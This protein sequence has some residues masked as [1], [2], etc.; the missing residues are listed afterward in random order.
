MHDPSHDA[1]I[2]LDFFDD[3]VSFARNAESNGMS[4]FACSVL[5]DGFKRIATTCKD[6]KNV[7]A[8]LGIH[9]WWV[10]EANLHDFDDCFDQTRWIGEVGL[11]FSPRRPH[12][13]LQ[14]QV[15]EHVAHRCS[16]SGNKIMSIHSIRS[17]NSVMQILN[18]TACLHNNTCIF[19]WFSGSTDDLW[20]AIRAGCYFSINER[21]A[22]TKRAR[23]Q[24]KLIPV[25]RL[26]LET[27]LPPQNNPHV[28]IDD[29]V[30][31]LETAR[32][33]LEGIRNQTLDDQLA[34]NWL[35]LLRSTS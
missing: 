22:Q 5:P 31:S 8:G 34:K 25:E 24:L 23:E 35:E 28:T 7:H 30:S 29:V 10:A 32:T 14:I 13:D 6:H 4:L 33:S 27:D 12:H 20:R 2:H 18:Q 3:P 21:Q 19:H 9:P 11:D 17:A 1:H 26:L 16:E 15:F